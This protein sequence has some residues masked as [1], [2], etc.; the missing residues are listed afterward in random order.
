MFRCIN[1]LGLALNAIGA[2]LLIVFTSPG[3]N[4][5]ETGEGLIGWINSP[6]PKQRAINLRRYRIHK[7][8][9]KAGVVLLA[10][11]YIFQLFAVIIG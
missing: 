2:V 4:V 8:G 10:V 11:G 3:L 6:T 9:F 7:Y 1:V 5:T